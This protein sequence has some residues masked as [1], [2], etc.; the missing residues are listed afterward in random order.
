MHKVPIVAYYEDGLS[1]IATQGR[2][3]FTRALIEV[4]A[5]RELKQEVIM[6]VP[7][8]DGTG[9]TMECICMEYEWKPPLCLDCHV[10]GHTKEQYPKRVSETVPKKNEVLPDGFITVNSR[11]K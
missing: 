10:F 7:K 4:S 6:A 1:L 2:L 11:K 5:D 9:H 8:V 3:G